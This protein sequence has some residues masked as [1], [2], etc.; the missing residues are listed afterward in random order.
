MKKIFCIMGKSGAGKSTIINSLCNIND[1]MI[2]IKSY[3]TR[4][5]RNEED[6]LTH[7]F[8]DDNF[9]ESHKDQAIAVYHSNHGYHS[10]VDNNSF[11][12][13]HFINLYAIDSKEFVNFSKKYKNQYKI[14]GIYLEVD[15]EERKKRLIERGSDNYYSLE[16]H[17][18]SD[19]L[20]KSCLEN[21][22]II[23]ITH[24]DKEQSVKLINNIIKERAI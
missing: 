21:Y 18:S 19:F 20:K 4:G 14:Y 9:Y 7:V 3:T 15:E 17:L 2:A 10:W 12:D 16:E 11:F 5:A 24:I 6:K 23:N 1:N 13:E 8:V 22:D